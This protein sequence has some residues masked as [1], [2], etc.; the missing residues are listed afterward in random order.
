MNGYKVCYR[1]AGKC[2]YIRHF[3]TYTFK[4]AIGA[5]Q[6]YIRYPPTARDDGHALIKPI[7][8]IIPVSEDEVKAGIWEELP[9]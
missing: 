8:T 5:M 1:E 2:E 6:G 9:F 4:Q 7:W 3:L